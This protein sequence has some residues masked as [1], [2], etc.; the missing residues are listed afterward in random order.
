MPRGNENNLKPALTKDE[1]RKR[2]SKGG[3]ASAAA[4]RAAKTYRE[5]AKWLLDSSMDS[6]ELPDH[7][8]DVI[9]ALGNRT[10]KKDTG[11]LILVMASFYR[12]CFREYDKFAKRFI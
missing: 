3:K 7:I 12:I 5:A 1:A 4:R 2:G 9:H 8:K 10:S 11:A 6:K